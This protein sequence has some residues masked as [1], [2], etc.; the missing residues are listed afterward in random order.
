MSATNYSNVWK[1][2]ATCDCWDGT[3]EANASGDTVTVDSSAVGRCVGFWEGSK[4]FGND[5]CTEWKMWR[6]L[7]D[8][9]VF[10]RSIWPPID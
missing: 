8:E 9:K 5:K 1:N 10:K 2:C 4:K 3:R 7:S 6:K